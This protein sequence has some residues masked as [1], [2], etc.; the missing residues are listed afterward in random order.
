MYFPLDYTGKLRHPSQL[1]EAFFEGFFLFVILWVIRKKSFFD[2]FLIAFYLIG[3]GVVRFF[4]EFYREPD[5]QVGFIWNFLSM[6][7][8]LCILMMLA[9]AGVLLYTR[10]RRIE[11]NAS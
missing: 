1:Y 6:G 11:G 7:Q 2:G 8:V 5:I 10:G 9:G 4:I 3:Y